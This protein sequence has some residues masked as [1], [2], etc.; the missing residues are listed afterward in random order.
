M[1]NL[2]KIILSLALTETGMTSLIK[3]AKTLKGTPRQLL[4]ALVND[5]AKVSKILKDTNAKQRKEISETIQEQ[6]KEH[7]E[8]S[9]LSSSWILSGHYKPTTPFTGELTITTKEG[10]SYTYPGVPMQTWEAMKKAKGQNGSGAGSIFWATYLRGHKGTFISQA[11]ASV[12][13]L[14]GIK[15]RSPEQY[16]GKKISKIAKMPKLK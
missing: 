15:A 3:I 10:G 13:K 14:A 2:F 1:G 9:M 11:T 8:F 4:K 5:P 12:F 16:F 7:E 6:Q